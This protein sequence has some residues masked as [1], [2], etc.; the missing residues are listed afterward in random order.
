MRKRVA[1]AV[2]AFGFLLGL[3][4]A[5]QLA[6]AQ[7]FSAQI[8]STAPNAASRAAAKLYVADRKVRIETPEL[9]GDV[10]IVDAAIPAAYLVRPAQRVF[11]DS[12][13]SS[14]LTRLFVPLD[15][16]APCR[17]WQAMAEVAGISDTA[18][19]RCVPT[20]SETVDGRNTRKFV[21]TSLR[22]RSTRWVDVN[23]KFPIKIETEDGAV[24]ALSAINEAPQPP[25]KFRIPAGYKKFDPR[26]VIEQMKR[27]DIWV[28]PTVDPDARL[29]R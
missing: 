6:Q 16:A 10:L 27:S 26:G 2:L 21:V 1:R 5:P 28:E 18:Q 19:W 25:E 4:S 14:H 20:G 9:P 3:A 22:G 11:M 29:S 15:P 13:Q 8:I 7:Q 12:K 17:Q 24:L 23:L